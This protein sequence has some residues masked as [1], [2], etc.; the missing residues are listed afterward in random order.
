F[1]LE[2]RRVL[3][4]SRGQLYRSSFAFQ[5][6]SY[7]VQAPFGDTFAIYDF[8]SGVYN[9]TGLFGPYSGLK[10]MTALP[11]H[12]FWAA[13]APRGAGLSWPDHS[14]RPTVPRLSGGSIGRILP[15][16]P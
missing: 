1:L 8:S 11:R 13:E 6:Y 14:P 5:S 2:L 15:R 7:D 4:R 12:S 10:Y 3:F 9:I 16:E